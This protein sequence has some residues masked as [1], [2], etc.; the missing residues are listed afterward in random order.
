MSTGDP[1]ADEV[2]E[3]DRLADEADLLTTLEANARVRE[4]LRDTKREVAER[5]RQGASK[6]EL[7]SLREKVSQ[8]EQA[9]Q[10]YR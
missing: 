8:L 6:L 4:V 2:I 5:E 9:V 3:H 10:R 1:E 7:A